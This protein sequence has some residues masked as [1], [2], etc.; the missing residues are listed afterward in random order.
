M[1]S[2]PKLLLAQVCQL[3]FTIIEVSNF[4]GGMLLPAFVV[5]GL[6]TISGQDR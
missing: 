3:R 5:M 1:K 6:L 2:V 4:V